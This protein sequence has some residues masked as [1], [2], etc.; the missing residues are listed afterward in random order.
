LRKRVTALLSA[1]LIAS[2]MAA[3]GTDALANHGANL[4]IQVGA[5]LAERLPGE[6]L[7]FLAPYTVRVHRGDTIKFDLYAGHAATLLPSDESAQDWLDEN[8]YGTRAP[9]SPL[10]ADDE[11]GEYVDNFHMIDTP[12]DTTCGNTGEAACDYDGRTLVHSG[13]VFSQPVEDGQ[14]FPETMAFT[15]AIDAQPGE[16]VWVV[17]LAYPRQR[18]KVLVV[19]NND[20]VTTQTEI[21]TARAQQL[22]ADQEWA[23]A[24]H[25]K[26]RTK[27]SSHVGADGTRVWDVWAGIDN[28]HASLNQFYPRKLK[29][30]KGQKVRW[31][32]SQALSQVHTAT[33]PIP[34]V[35]GL[36]RDYFGT[37]ECDSPTDADV[38]APPPAEGQDPVCPGG[39]TLEF[40]FGQL[41]TGSGNNRWSGPNDV[42]H[43]GFRGT[44]VRG[45]T[46][47]LQ[48]TAPFTVEMDRRTGKDPMQ[49]LCFVHGGMDGRIAVE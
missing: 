24:M 3:P 26:M 41:L 23:E 29:V 14:E 5:G 25:S 48:G 1:A 12:S 31:H 28:D 15:T 21:D 10:I 39:T 47:P 44:D 9:Y 42:E 19:G 4:T 27:R 16:R 8:W 40:E 2:T 49:Y 37:F 7:R 36:P 32:F 45:L 30:E 20:P 18:M 6:S 35:F 11:E 22:A 17:N 43:S 38:P 46:P 33:M 34:A 13:T